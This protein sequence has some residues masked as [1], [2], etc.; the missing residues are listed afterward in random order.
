MN[1][2]EYIPKG[3]ENAIS[4][5]DLCSRTGLC[6]RDLRAYIEKANQESD[7]PILNLQDGK[8]YFIPILPEEK[9]L[10]WQC[11]ASETSRINKLSKKTRKWREWVSR[12]GQYEMEL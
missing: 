11:I 1:I 10:V 8:G 12:Q 9:H 5:K 2:R 4:R 7:E 6:D 3:Q